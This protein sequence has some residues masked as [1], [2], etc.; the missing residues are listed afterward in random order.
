MRGLIQ[1]NFFT[2]NEF[3]HSQDTSVLSQKISKPQ[4]QPDFLDA[5][6]VE[7]ALKQNMAA[8]ADDI[9][10][11]IGVSYN[12]AA[13]SATERRY[14]KKGH[15]AVNLKTGAWIDHKNSEM[16]GGPL[17]MLT[18]LKGLSFKEAVDYGASWAG[19]SQA[20][21]PQARISI[22]TVPQEAE[23]EALEK[24]DQK[25]IEKAQALW[26]R[27]KS[28]KGTLAERY[29]REH[30]KIEGDLSHDLKYLPQFRDRYSGNS[31]P[32]LMA[33]ARS[34]EGSITAAQLTFLDPQTAFKA[35]I[36]TP[37]KSYGVLKGSAVTL[38]EDKDSNLLFIA[39]G[40]ETALSLKSAEIKGTIKA[41]L[42]LS[43]IKRLVPEN[44]HT[45]IIICADHDA[46]DSPA[47]Q[48]LEESVIALKEKGFSVTVIKPDKLHEDFNDV[49][50]REGPQK[51][52][53]IIEKGGLPQTQKQSLENNLSLQGKLNESTKKKTF[54]QK[55]KATFKESTMRENAHHGERSAAVFREKKE[56]SLS[57]AFPGSDGNLSLKRKIQE[58]PPI[59][60]E[61]KRKIL[62]EEF[63]QRSN[64]PR[65]NPKVDKKISEEL[66][67][68]MLGD[69]FYN[70]I[71]G[72]TRT[73]KSIETEKLSRSSMI[74]D[75]QEDHTHC[76]QDISISQKPI[77]RGRKR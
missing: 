51:V 21:I 73:A 29:L 76:D 43:N 58:H 49:L 7:N 19:L 60:E 5:K 23:K 77:S 68:E 35:D 16:S 70:R 9:F 41:S 71:Y 62:G 75:I 53:E 55:I 3:S 26:N 39:E 12:H 64:H 37:K 13:S 65:I 45:R 24:N 18:K 40:V 1:K 34:A 15:I 52:K 61:L 63:Y 14:G 30:R 72:K 22:P 38:Q 66:K 28:I 2:K 10:S 32:C 17:H 27:G 36:V 11:S 50:K 48:N 46:L 57:P 33:A 20:S 6:A 74:S 56:S 69:E 25:R 4:R 44:P 67:R 42:G 59:S 31:Y 47:T 54:W 8:F